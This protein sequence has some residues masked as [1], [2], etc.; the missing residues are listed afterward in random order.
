MYSADVGYEH[1]QC[2]NKFC[3]AAFQQRFIAGESIVKVLQRHV[4]PPPPPREE[5]ECFR[6]APNPSSYAYAAARSCVLRSTVKR[7]LPAALPLVRDGGEMLT[8]RAISYAGAAVLVPPES[9]NK[10]AELPGVPA[11]RERYAGSNTASSAGDADAASGS[12]L[13]CSTL[14]GL[15][16]WCFRLCW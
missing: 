9:G 7:S 10:G 11:E 6:S 8:P 4:A 2:C 5:E 12:N 15:S 1:E 13:I 14:T 3:S 16:N